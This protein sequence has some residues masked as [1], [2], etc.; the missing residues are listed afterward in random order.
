MVAEDI[1]L[2]IMLGLRMLVRSGTV[3]LCKDELAGVS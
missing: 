2:V 1:S 3:Y